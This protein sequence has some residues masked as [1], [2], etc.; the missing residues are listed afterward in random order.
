MKIVLIAKEFILKPVLASI[1]LAIFCLIVLEKEYT[2]KSKLIPIDKN[3]NPSQ[4]SSQAV[5]GLL[6]F[7]LSNQSMS[8]LS[9]ANYFHLILKSDTTIEKLMFIKVNDNETLIENFLD[10]KFEKITPLDIENAVTK[11]KTNNIALDKDRISN[12]ITLNVSYSD[13]LIAQ[14]ISLFLIN[15][16]IDRQR[17]ANEDFS[18]NRKQYLKQRIKETT[19]EL[20]K[21][22][23]KLIEFR[24]SNKNLNSV[25]LMIES[26]KMERE[27]RL[28][29]NIINGLSE[30]L[31]KIKINEI[32][33]NNEIQI[34]DTPSFPQSKSSPRG[35]IIALFCF[36]I[37]FTVKLF[38]TL[39]KNE[40][41]Q[42]LKN[43]E[44][45]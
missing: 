27:R 43:I 41:R 44:I 42:F 16:T 2:S 37:L 39:Y 13:P 15:E 29:E 21:V 38:S 11:F 9:S 4:S 3:G 14:K 30:E 5:Q 8:S 10:E 19:I 18:S 12:L 24:T 40:L 28:I 26:E 1:L 35:S 17:K 6:G 7:N 31:E 33:D 22:E 45:N 23:E 36:I 25:Y 20:Q 32:T 34:L